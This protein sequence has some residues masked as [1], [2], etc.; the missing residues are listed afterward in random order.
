[1]L[2]CLKLKL[3]PETTRRE[4]TNQLHMKKYVNEKHLTLST[5]II[6]VVVSLTVNSIG[7]FLRYLCQLLMRGDSVAA[8]GPPLTSPR[9]T[10]GS[11]SLCQSSLRCF[12]SSV[13]TT[14]TSICKHCQIIN[15]LFTAFIRMLE[16]VTKPWM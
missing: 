10:L 15:Q 9:T 5:D 14:S 7:E 8:D 12:I 1:M 13:F 2:S 3:I 4:P 6:L 16:S 11:S